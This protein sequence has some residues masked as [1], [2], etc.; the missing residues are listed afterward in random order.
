MVNFH[1]TFIFPS[2]YVPL[3]M[4]CVMFLC[5]LVAEFSLAITVSWGSIPKTRGW[6]GMTWFEAVPN[7]SL[8]RS[9]SLTLNPAVHESAHFFVF[10]FFLKNSLCYAF[11]LLDFYFVS[12]WCNIRLMDTKEKWGIIML[13]GPLAQIWPH[14]GWA[15]A[16]SIERGETG[17]ALVFN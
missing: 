1:W 4:L 17:W 3:A 9:W 14:K 13:Y 5:N 6:T 10:S 2:F 7:H 12:F 16:L 15:V 8:G 11:H